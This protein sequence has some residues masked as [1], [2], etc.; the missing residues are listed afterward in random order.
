[1]A[2][3]KTKILAP[4]TKGGLG[5]LKTEFV[6]IVPLKD[7]ARL[8]EKLSDEISQKHLDELI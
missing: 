2:N 8:T 1:M 3:K 6:E 4:L 7:N 5:H